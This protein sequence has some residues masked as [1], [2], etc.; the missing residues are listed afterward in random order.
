MMKGGLLRNTRGVALILTILIVSLIVAL[1]LE[2]N[3][4]MRS[5]VVSAGNIG[6]GL[7]ALYAAKSGIS[8]GLAILMKDSDTVDTLMDDWALPSMLKAFSAGSQT[9]LAGGRFELDIEDL[10]GKIQVNNL[11]QKP[12]L[13][14]AFKR[15]LELDE[16][17][18]D[19][20]TVS[21]ITD[22]VMDWMDGADEED[23]LMR[24]YGAEDDYYMS[25]ERPYH[26]KNEPLDSVEEILLVKGMTPDLFYGTEDHLGI[27]PYIGVYGTGEININTADPKFPE[28]PPVV[29]SSLHEQMTTDIAEEMANYRIDSD[30]DALKVKTWYREA[31][32]DDIKIPGSLVTTSSNHFQITS[33]GQF[34][35]IKK[36]VEAVVERST[37]GFRI[38]SWKIG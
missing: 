2:F 22:S 1:T 28:A 9:L 14:K 6:H 11:T 18:L 20:E 4:T 26:C 38:L 29:L 21:I 25:L 7:K 19:E 17:G 36:R 32:P 13:E 5:H 8:C 34:G 3:R 31:V 30:E 10:S 24:F 33:V 37:S 27:E 35:D 23:D 12:E 16:F 15:F